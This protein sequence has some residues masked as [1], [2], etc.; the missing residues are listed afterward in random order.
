[1]NPERPLAWALSKLGFGG[2]ASPPRPQLSIVL[3]TYQRRSF[4]RQAVKTIRTNG[5]AVPY[6]IIVVDGGSTDGTV[7]WLV[8]QKDVITIVQHNRGEFRGRRLPRR[9]WGYFMN[10]AFRASHGEYVLMISDDC[11]LV[12]GAA[13]RALD[14][15]RAMRAEGRPVGAMAF[16]FR[17]WPREREYYV[18]FTLGGKLIVNH[19]IYVRSALEAVGWADEDTYTFYKADGDLCLRMWRAGYEVVDCPGAYV[20]HH[21]DAN[22]AVRKTNRA[23]L[24]RDRDAY[25][26][27]WKGIFEMGAPDVQQRRAVSFDD[28]DRTAEAFREAEA[29]EAAG[30]ADLRGAVEEP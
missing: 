13:P 17:N 24:Q 25:V 20:E 11:L 18:Q 2:A 27:R 3:G 15:L 19:G 10:I 30:G 12:R 8:Q 23:V 1:M 28:R 22:P 29:E 7:E 5:I 6:E 26:R 14:R 21:E 4:L 16:Y 9:S